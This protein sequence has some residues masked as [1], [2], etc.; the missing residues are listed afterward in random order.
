MQAIPQ[1]DRAYCDLWS[2]ARS[3]SRSDCDELMHLV[4]TNESS[5][6]LWIGCQEQTDKL[7]VSLALHR[8]RAYPQFHA[9]MASSIMTGVNAA[10]SAVAALALIGNSAATAGPSAKPPRPGCLV[11]PK[12]E[13]KSAQTH[14]LLRSRS[15]EYVRTGRVFGRQYWYC[16]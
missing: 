9:R 15:G 8:C 16:K 6:G 5:A 2:R 12:Q 7:P 10:L 11:V 3:A 4:F 1:R 14:N 13:Y